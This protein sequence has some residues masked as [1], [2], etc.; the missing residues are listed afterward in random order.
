MTCQFYASTSY[1][2]LPNLNC[3]GQKLGVSIAMD[4]IFDPS[5]EL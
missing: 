3:C 2:L 1:G 5:L 4:G